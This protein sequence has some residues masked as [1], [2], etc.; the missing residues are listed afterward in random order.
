[1]VT[2]DT[3]QLKMDRV[4]GGLQ[5]F[6]AVSINNTVSIENNPLGMLRRG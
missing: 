1:M 2:P 4:L 3:Y 6:V 5:N